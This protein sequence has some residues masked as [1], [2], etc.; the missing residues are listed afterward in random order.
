MTD[1]ND[2]GKHKLGGDGNKV[3]LRISGHGWCCATKK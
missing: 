3:Q 1:D 2:E